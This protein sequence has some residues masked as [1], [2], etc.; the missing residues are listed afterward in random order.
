MEIKSKMHFLIF[1]NTKSGDGHG[2]CY[3]ELGHPS[4]IIRY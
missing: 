2:K 1:V 4:L 3:I